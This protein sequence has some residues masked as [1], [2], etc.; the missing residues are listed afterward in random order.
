MF[1]VILALV[2]AV[3][4]TLKTRQQLCLEVLALRHQVQ[5]LQ[6]GKKRPTL[7]AVDRLLWVGLK[8]VWPGW[9][10][11]LVIVRPETVVGWHR[12]AFRTF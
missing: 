3:V 1:D 4:A 6:R 11:P 12:K 8:K 10:N 7:K 5:V 9:R 2:E